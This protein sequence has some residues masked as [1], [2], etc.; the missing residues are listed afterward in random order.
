MCMHVCVR[1]C[2]CVYECMHVHVYVR[3]CVCVSSCCGCEGLIVDTVD[4]VNDCCS[5]DLQYSILHFIYVSAGNITSHHIRNNVI[6]DLF[7]A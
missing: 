1:M 2:I 6:I 3:V 5:L 7:F 4:T